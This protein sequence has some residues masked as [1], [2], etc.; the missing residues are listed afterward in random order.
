MMDYGSAN[1][2]LGGG[3]HNRAPLFLNTL[4]LLSVYSAALVYV[5][6][7]SRPGQQPLAIPRGVVVQRLACEQEPA[8]S[9]ALYLPS[10]YSSGAAWPV[11]YCFD[12][13]AQ[14]TIPVEAFKDAAEKYGYIVAG[15]NNSRNGPSAIISAAINAMWKDTHARFNIDDT[16]IYA[17]GFSG[18]ARVASQFGYALT[19]KIAGIIACGAGFATNI[20]P[21][22]STPFAVFATVG[23]ADFNYPELVHLARALDQAGVANRLRVFDGGHQWAPK[24]LCLESIG[25]MQLQAMKQG[26]LERQASFVDGLFARELAA[27]EALQSAGKPYEACRGYESLIKDFTGLKELSGPEK[28]VAEL[29]NSKE[30]K[31]AQKKEKDDIDKQAAKEK[32]LQTLKRTALGRAATERGDSIDDRAVNRAAEASEDR[33]AALADL[34]RAIAELRKKA[35]ESSPD[36]VVWQRVLLGFFVQCYETG[37]GLMQAKNYAAAAANLQLAADVRPDGR[38]VFYNLACAYSRLRDKSKALAAL[39]RAVENGYEDRQSLESDPDLDAIRSEPEFRRIVEDL[40]K[41]S[42]N[43]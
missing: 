13:G 38:G 9:Y 43:L 30:V 17:A 37:A 16:R 25:W 36:R 32:E 7:G 1:S 8:Q 39:K 41:K 18:G 20:T 12:P 2:A 26:K 6:G 42:R 4:L 5:V 19:G 11:L 15:S 21:S 14:G 34:K 31:Q 22:R 10:S 29:R 28:K 23:T 27:A 3:G 24:E 35:E 33:A 40:N